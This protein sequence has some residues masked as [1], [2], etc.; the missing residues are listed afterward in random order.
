MTF[1]LYPEINVINVRLVIF[2]LVHLRKR[3]IYAHK[4]ISTGGCPWFYLKLTLVEKYLGFCLK[5]DI[6]LVIPSSNVKVE[7]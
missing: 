5:I 1:F 7:S 6:M 4:Q 2:A 3:F